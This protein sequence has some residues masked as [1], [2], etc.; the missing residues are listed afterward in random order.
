MVLIVAALLGLAALSLGGGEV[1]AIPL[2]IFVIVVGI[3]WYAMR[4]RQNAGE[5]W[6]WK[7]RV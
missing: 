3:Q 7:W 4:R 1:L 2:L 5:W 6:P